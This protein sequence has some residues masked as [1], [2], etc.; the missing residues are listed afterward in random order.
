MNDLTLVTLLEAVDDRGRSDLAAIRF[1]DTYE[2]AAGPG[3]KVYPPT[4]PRD[5][6]PYVFERRYDGSGAPLET[7]MLDSV[8]SQAN[9][10]EEALL[11]AVDDGRIQLPLLIVETTVHG[12]EIRL[13]SLEMPHRCSD[14]YLRDA[15]TETGERFDST[16]V[17]RELRRAALRN[18]TTVYR[19]C[20]TAL[21]LGTWD[22]HR[23]RPELSFKA[24]RVYVSELYGIA[25]E[26][27]TGWRVGSRL[28]PLGMLGGRVRRTGEQPGDWELIEIEG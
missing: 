10:V 7:V 11:D 27:Q 19:S 28:D 25:P 23:G 15:E 16:D 14:A 3:A 12:R 21:I 13:T 9:R 5:G 24:P 6:I 18:A 8:G 17:G 4:Y 22:S 2:A 26:S 1:R 20:P